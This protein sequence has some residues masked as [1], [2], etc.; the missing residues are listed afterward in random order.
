M[1]DSGVSSSPVSPR[2]HTLRA[3]QHGRPPNPPEVGASPYIPSD[4][5]LKPRRGANFRRPRDF[6]KK[7]SLG[8]NDLKRRAGPLGPL[9]VVSPHRAPQGREI[10]TI[11]ALPGP[12]CR[13]RLTLPGEPWRRSPTQRPLTLRGVLDGTETPPSAARSR[14]TPLDG[15]MVFQQI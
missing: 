1:D 14:R 5:G 8:G 4:V 10:P 13:P 9:P 7:S 15:E 11:R 3:T 2:T 12:G 6:F